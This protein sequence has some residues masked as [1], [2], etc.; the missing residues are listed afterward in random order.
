MYVL[1]A[2]ATSKHFFLN[3]FPLQVSQVIAS[4][5]NTISTLMEPSPYSFHGVYIKKENVWADNL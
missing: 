5:M 2:N 4:A 3:R 1:P